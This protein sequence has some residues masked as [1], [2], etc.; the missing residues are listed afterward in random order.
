MAAKTAQGVR[1]VIDFNEDQKAAYRLATSPDYKYHLFYGG[2][3]SGKSYLI[4]TIIILRALIAP[5]SRHGIF[6]L[7]R[8]SCDTTLFSK[9]L[10]EVFDSIL[11]GYLQRSDVDV[12]VS[13]L[14]VTLH[15]GS[16][17]HFDGL[18]ENRLKKIDGNE[19]QTVW[20]NECNEFSYSHV[21]RL[22]GRMRG[23]KLKEDGKP[24]RHKLF[25]D[26]NPDSEADWECKAFRDGV[27]PADGDALPNHDK[28][29]MMKLRPAANLHIV[30]EDYIDNM[31]ASM[32]AADRK[33][34]IDGDWASANPDALF[35][36]AMFRDHRI[37]KAKIKRG[38]SE[39]DR[40]PKETLKML[41]DQ[42]ITVSRINVA[43]DPA[44]TNDAKSDLHGITV[45][46]VATIHNA[47]EGKDEEHVYVLADYSRRGTPDAIC[48]K[49]VDA[50]HAWGASCIVIENNA[51]G[52][53]L[54]STLRT[55]T[56]LRPKFLNANATT[57][58][59]QS[60]AEPVSAQYERGYVHHVG[61]LPEL[62][63]QMCEFGSAASK[64]KSPDRMD[65]VVWGITELLKLNH[66]R[67][68]KRGAAVVRHG[69][70]LR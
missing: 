9:T 17:L 40:T 35:N 32:S 44:K 22:V 8:N 52:L 51:A 53:W 18:D 11:P 36:E 37:P 61:K 63:Q 28:W 2:G 64:R 21:S 68:I 29:V 16:L 27:N 7:T 55:H 50:Y 70:R 1:P 10:Y 12:S 67:E 24:L 33:R 38:G 43:T 6:R 58:G 59:K 65:A 47:D 4:L 39:R 41:S 26:C 15:N 60:R 42:G 31:A 23:I 13:D 56:N 14:T 48:K 46:G 20:L 66:P 45:Q 30:G 69:N 25:A 54:D 62:E 49:I 57:G 3:G 5:G 34:Y 19:F